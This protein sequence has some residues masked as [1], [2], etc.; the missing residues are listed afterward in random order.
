V[1]TARI[2]WGHLSG[3]HG[4]DEA[5]NFFVSLYQKESFSFFTP[6]RSFSWTQTHV[7]R[8]VSFTP[9]RARAAPSSPHRLPR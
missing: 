2:T 3:V 8:V 9:A 7:P 6:L 4:P 1:S 5:K